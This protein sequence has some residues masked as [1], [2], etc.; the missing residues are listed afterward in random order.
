MAFR[1]GIVAA[2]TQSATEFKEMARRAE[3]AGYSS[4]LMPDTSGPVL[5]PFSALATAAAV[6]TSLHVGNWVLAG[7]FRNPV[8]LAREAATLDLLSEGRYELGI[9]AGRHDNDYA[10]LGLVRPVSGGVRLNHL[11][12]CLEI[13]QRLFQGETV[14]FHGE[15]YSVE[16]ATLYPRPVRSVPILMASSRPRSIALAGRYAS[17]V[18]LAAFSR[19]WFLQQRLALQAA[20]GERFAGIELAT[21]LWPVPADDPGAAQTAR[22]MIRR[23]SGADADVL[24]ANQAPTVIV[25]SREAMIEQLQERRETLGISYITIGA[26]LA[27]WFAPVVAR[28]TGT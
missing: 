11:A 13:T 12:E 10:S 25:G 4:L 3:A 28:L 8:L 19:D 6:T 5:S 15:Y 17:I 14:T 2:Q 26:P 21:I 27:E 7:D 1:F 9:G 18:A 24:I 23:I 20:A 16:N 22:M